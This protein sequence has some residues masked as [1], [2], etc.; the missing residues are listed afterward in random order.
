MNVP[1]MLYVEEC[2]NLSFAVGVRIEYANNS[3]TFSR[4][5]SYTKNGFS[6]LERNRTVNHVDMFT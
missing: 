2:Q 1:W 5:Y 4:V 6:I 3:N